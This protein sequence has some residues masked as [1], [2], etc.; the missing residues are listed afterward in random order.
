[1]GREGTTEER[2]GG[3]ALVTASTYLILT[4][5]HWFDCEKGYNCEFGDKKL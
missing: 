3:G 1:M 5:N 4:Y 2:R